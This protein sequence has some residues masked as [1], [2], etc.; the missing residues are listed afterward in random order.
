MSSP[1]SSAAWWST[2]RARR[3]EHARHRPGAAVRT[4][5]ARGAAH[6]A[7]ARPWHIRRRGPG[8]P[9]GAHR[10]RAAAGTQSGPA[11][12]WAVSARTAPPVPR[13]YALLY[14]LLLRVLPTAR[15]ER[16]RSGCA[17][18]GDW[19]GTR[20]RTGGPR[21]DRGAGTGT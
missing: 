3:N 1:W 18:A 6:A 7:L 13:G 8:R 21:S 5:M 14:A 2:G 20:R 11:H 4:G 10:G 9:H 17:R 12:R 16:G 19:A 15:Y